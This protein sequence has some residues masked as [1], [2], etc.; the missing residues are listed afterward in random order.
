MEEWISNGEEMTARYSPVI[1][2]TLATARVALEEVMSLVE[3]ELVRLAASNETGDIVT[4]DAPAAVERGIYFRERKPHLISYHFA[5]GIARNPR[6]EIWLD[7]ALAELRPQLE[8]KRVT[9]LRNSGNRELVFDVGI[10]KGAVMRSLLSGID[11]CIWFADDDGDIPAAEAVSEF[12][13]NDGR[14]FVV[15]VRHSADIVVSNGAEVTRR[16]DT[17]A[18]LLELA[19]IVV[20]DEVACGALSKTIAERI[21]GMAIAPKRRR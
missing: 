16:S 21:A 15:V 20:E 8:K 9:T 6:L 11:T 19:D 10:D 3:T 17:P 4:S 7:H 12:R 14:G 5:Q 1:A 2:D 13:E 18:R